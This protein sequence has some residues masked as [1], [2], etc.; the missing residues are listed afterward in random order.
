M[1][2]M[3]AHAHLE[4]NSDVMFYRTVD[5]LIDWLIGDSYKR[6]S[7]LAGISGLSN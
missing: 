7:P 4:G 3:S 2:F 6:S 5:W 1:I